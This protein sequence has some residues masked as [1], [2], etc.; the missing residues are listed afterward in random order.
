MASGIQFTG[1]KTKG[2]NFFQKIVPRKKENRQPNEIESNVTILMTKKKYSLAAAIRMVLHEFSEKIKNKEITPEL[3]ES[4]IAHYTKLMDMERMGNLSV[5]PKILDPH[6]LHCKEKNIYNPL[7][8]ERNSPRLKIKPFGG[9]SSA[10]AVQRPTIETHPQHPPIPSK[11]TFA[12]DPRTMRPHISASTFTHS[13]GSGSDLTKVVTLQDLRELREGVIDLPH[14]KSE[15]DRRVTVDLTNGTDEVPPLSPMPTTSL[16]EEINALLISFNRFGLSG[17]F[18]IEESYYLK[19]VG[20]D[21]RDQ[22]CV[23]SLPLTTIRNEFTYIPR[24]DSGRMESPITYSPMHISSDLF[25]NFPQIKD[26][27]VGYNMEPKMLMNWFA[28]N[29]PQILTSVYEDTATA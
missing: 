9:E 29:P 20:T 3:Y 23:Y 28:G 8:E 25:T 2:I 10:D 11:H 15:F 17:I 1:V 26:Q 13:T 5:T 18:Y 6:E 22:P 4:Y 16:N 12:P 21:E 27:P 7:F 19:A 14:E 24:I